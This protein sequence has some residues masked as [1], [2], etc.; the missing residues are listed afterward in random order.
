[1]GGMLQEE[2]NPKLAGQKWI[3]TAREMATN[4]PVLGGAMLAM[5]M[6]T[7]RAPWKVEPANQSTE[8]HKWAEFVDTCRHDMAFTWSEHISEILQCVVYGASYFERVH[9]IRHGES[10][11]PEFDSKH[12][13][14]LIG[15]AKMAPRSMD[16]LSY[17]PW[18]YD[19][20]TA[21][22]TAM[23][24]M[25]AP[26]FRER[27]IP[28]S[29]LAVFRVRS[30]KDSPEGRS[31]FRAA[32]VPYYFAKRIREVEAIGV[33][34]DLAGLP[35]MQ[36]P[37]ECFMPGAS[38]GQKA[39]RAHFEQMVPRIRRG[40]YE[41]LVRPSELDSKGNPTGYKFGLVNSGGR[42]PVDVDAIIRRYE[43]RM[44]IAFLCEF[45]LLGTDKVGSFALSSDKTELFSLGLGAILDMICEVY[46]RTEIPLL[47]KL[48]G[49]PQELTPTL[50]HGDVEKVNLVDVASYVSTLTGAG[51]LMPSE[52]L[53]KHLLE[54][55]DL[56]QAKTIDD[57]APATPIAR[58]ELVE[59]A[60]IEESIAPE[61]ERI[62]PDEPETK[63][64]EPEVKAADTALNGA[65]VTAAQGIVTSVAAGE[66]PRDTG[67]SMLV[68]FFTM[69][70]AR[71][72]RV[73]G[74]VGRGF[75][76]TTVAKLRDGQSQ[77]HQDAHATVQNARDRGDLVKKPCSECGDSNSE[78]HH[79][80]Y[81]KPLDVRWLCRPCHS[82]L[83]SRNK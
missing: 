24:Q 9:K 55:A 35:D 82:A 81:D 11:H 78:A 66:L 45:L 20:A 48:N 79:D 17:E 77:R 75:V 6:L 65:Q 16:S 68:E 22:V 36:I 30:S 33:E 28:W 32:Y 23:R 44:L 70:V 1:M 8:A 71:A 83:H 39:M 46:N 3:K 37:L 80:D 63:A 43:S 64:D 12:N 49:V 52:E 53:D 13:D 26:D 18:V 38:D 76:P 59:L 34:R 27:I 50:E 67:V 21:R 72:E 69:D 56:P 42:R 60:P 41:G 57:G 25:P 10:D 62:E 2:F 73:M 7:R 29:K 4:E 15:W 47:M 19:E 54:I 40:E 51:H 61:R 5:E 31:L 14:G 58:R 74:S